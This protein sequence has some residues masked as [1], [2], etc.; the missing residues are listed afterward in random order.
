MWSLTIA[1]A[2]IYDQGMIYQHDVRETHAASE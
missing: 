1:H 2:A